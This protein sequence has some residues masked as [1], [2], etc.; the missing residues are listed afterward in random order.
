MKSILNFLPLGAG[1]GH[2]VEVK[3]SQGERNGKTSHF[4]WTNKSPSEGWTPA[5][6]PLNKPPGIG[7]QGYT[8]VS[9]AL[10]AAGAD[11]QMR[12]WEMSNFVKISY[13]LQW[14]RYPYALQECQPPNLRY[15][16]D[17]LQPLYRRRK[18]KE[19]KDNP[20]ALGTFL[21]FLAKQNKR[22]SNPKV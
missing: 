16:S 7:S 20:P 21:V 11:L 3:V 18:T 22:K 12:Q 4:M 6:F 10:T 1:V 2:M 17:L 15:S 13:Y 19:R 14:S 8:Q 9:L 5:W